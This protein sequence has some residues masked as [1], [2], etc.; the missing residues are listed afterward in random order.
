ML[1]YMFNINVCNVQKCLFF[2]FRNTLQ[3]KKIDC[4][5][6]IQHEYYKLLNWW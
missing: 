3:Q 2:S 6:W 4:N 5:K 1:K